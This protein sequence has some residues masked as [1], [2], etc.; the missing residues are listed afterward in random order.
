KVAQ[1]AG[2]VVREHAE[3]RILVPLRI[4]AAKV[5]LERAVAGA[6]QTQVMPSTGTRMRAKRRGIGG[7]HDR[8]VRVTGEMRGDPVEPVDPHRAHRT[9]GRVSLS[10]HEVVN[11]ERPSR[12]AEELAQ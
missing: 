3:G 6:Q 12:T 4:L 11:D 8:Q 5:V 9:R 2:R 10:V 1:L 7:G